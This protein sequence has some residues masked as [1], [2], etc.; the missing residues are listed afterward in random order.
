MES[1][2]S[3]CVSRGRSAGVTLSRRRSQVGVAVNKERTSYEK[4]YLKK[5]PGRS[6]DISRA[7]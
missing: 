3:S 7:V 5:E 2:R 6:V 4:L 1:G